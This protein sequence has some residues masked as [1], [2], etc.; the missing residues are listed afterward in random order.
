MKASD[1]ALTRRL[2]ALYAS[3]VHDVLRALSDQPCALPAELRPLDPRL[4]LAGRAW[5]FAGRHDPS[6]TA[7]DVLL[8]WATVLSQAPADHV[9]VCQPNDRNIALMGELSAETLQQR[10]GLGYVVD[11]GCRD[12]DFILELGY[13]VFH[14][15][16]TP[17]DVVTSHWLATGL[18]EPVRI[19][20]VTIHA[21]DYI[22]GD[23]DGVVVIPSALAADVITQTEAVASTESSIRDA[24]RSGMDPVQAYLKYR[25]F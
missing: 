21:G 25:K 20:E 1:D 10:G 12:T 6:A 3:A 13:P 23:R 15:F 14:R 2:A 4:K 19:G 24:L 22:L 16:F 17:T 7:H 11:G 5:P 9:L 8:A 18:G